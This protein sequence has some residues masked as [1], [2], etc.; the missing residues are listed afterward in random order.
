MDKRKLKRAVGIMLIL[1]MVIS[2]TASAFAASLNVTLTGSTYSYYSNGST[3]G[4]NKHGVFVASDPSYGAVFC[5]EHDRPEPM[6]IGTTKSMTIESFNNNN[7]IRKIL[8]YGYKGPAEW[9]GFSDSRYNNV[10]Q[11]FNGNVAKSKTQAC[12]VSVT[13]TALSIAYR[14]IGGNGSSWDV[15][16]LNA[17][18]NYINSKPAPPKGFEVYRMPGSGG[19]QDLF[20]WKYTPTG[21][22]TLTKGSNDPN[23]VVNKFPSHYSLAGAQYGVYTNSSLSNKVA[24]LTTNASGK[25]NKVTLDAG[26]YYIKEIKAPKGYVMDDKTYQVNIS[27]GNIVDLDV[28]D[29]AA[30]G[31]LA[32]KKVASNKDGVVDK[33]PGNYSLAG[34]EYTVYKDESLSASSKVGVLTTKSSGDTNM[35]VLPLG[36]YYVKETKASNGFKLDSKLH[37][38]KLQ[39]N[40][41]STITSTE[42][43][44]VGYAKLKKDISSDKHLTDLC[45]ENYSLAGAEYAVFDDSTGKKVGT[46]KTNAKGETAT[47]ALPTGSYYAK[48]IKAPKGFKLNSSETNTIT[49]KDGETKTFKATDAPS[50]DP[51][52]IK[53]KKTL[54]PGVDKNLSAAGAQYKVEYYKEFINEN[55]LEGKKPFRTWVIETK[56]INGQ[57]IAQLKDNYLVKDKSD[58]LFLNEKGRAV[59]LWG[60]YVITEELAPEGLARTEGIVSLQH[61]TFDEKLQTATV[62]KDVTAVEKAQTVSISISKVDKE[63]G[64]PVPQGYGSLEGAIFEISH[65]DPIKGENIV[66]GQVTT[67][68]KG[69]ASLGNL[70]PYTYK[71]KEIKAPDGYVKNTDI[72]E[73]KAGI[74]EPNTAN[75]DYEVEVPEQ[76]TITEIGKYEK[77]L[78]LNNRLEGA[79][80]QILDSNGKL[81]EEFTSTDKDFVIKGL[82]VGKYT[83]HEEKAPKGYV[84]AEDVP[85]EIKEDV[86]K[87]EVK[88][89]D[90]RVSAEKVDIETKEA[91][92]DAELAVKDSEGH[93]VD[94][95]TTDGEVHYISNLDYGK[96]YTLVETK[97]PAGYVIAEPVKF[98]VTGEDNIKIVMEDD[99]TKVQLNKVD[100]NNNLIKGAKLQLINDKKEVV[101][102]WTSTSKP[103]QFDRL[104]QGTYI[105]RETE[106]PEGYVKA[107]DVEVIVKDTADIQVGTMRDIR[108]YVE[109][110]DLGNDN[111][112][113]G[114][115]LEVRNSDGEVVDSWKSN[116]KPHYISNLAFGKSYTLVETKAPAGYVKI[117]PVDFTVEGLKDIEII[118]K[119][120]FIK[121][122][123]TK[124]MITGE[125]ELPGARLQVIDKDGN[126]IDEWVSSDK[127]HR[128]DRMPA[129]DYILKEI[130][131]A[132]GFVTAENIHF[133]VTE[134]GEV[135]VVTMRDEM[136]KT[137]ISKTDITTGENVV[138]AELSIYP[139]GEDGKAI[140][141][142]CFE[143]WITAETPH[144][145]EGLTIGKYVLREK[146]NS[147]AELGYVTA[148]EI[149]FEVK[150]TPEVQKV[151]MKDDYTK[152]E[153]TKNDVDGNPVVGATLSIVP[154]D[155]EGNPQYGE[156]FKTW[157]TE[158]DNPETKDIDESK[159]Y[160][161][162]L[163][164]GKYLLVENSAP[165]GYVKADPVE[166]EVKDTPEVQKYSMTDTR[167]SAVKV[168]TEGSSV[169]DVELTVFDKDG[170]EVD[171]WVTEGVKE[172]NHYISGLTENNEYVLKETKV[173]NGYV[174]AS[175]IT[176]TTSSTDNKK[177]I[178]VVMT[179]IR[180]SVNKT[181][182]DNKPLEGAELT[183]F[184]KDGNEIDKWI[185]DGKTHYITGLVE[186]SEYTLK[187]TKT[188]DGYATFEDIKFN[189]SEIK[190]IEINAIDEEIKVEITKIDEESK[191][192]LEGA[193][194]QVLNKEGKVVEEWT[195][196]T[197]AHKITKL[198]VGDY[199]LR[200]IEAPKG[201][202]KAQDQKFTVKD[203][204]EIQAFTLANEL[205]PIIPKTGDNSPILLYMLLLILSSGLIAAFKRKDVR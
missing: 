204:S 92:K 84:R 95:W 173:P 46:L 63:T 7:K 117:S 67:D 166:F 123:I 171:K 110:L 159:M 16:G 14:E 64:K 56:D 17:F 172:E 91:L 174:K 177:N 168:D 160:I 118:A 152:T 8:Y 154:I 90:I 193:K 34:A 181:S 143:T 120:D 5:G 96:T 39:H 105:M 137:L 24:T 186:N 146:L 79:V 60:T 13:S 140:E 121:V 136:T 26:K 103:V 203:T 86:V 66:D 114:A 82:P 83:L 125:D 57:Y 141:G 21:D 196:T 124:K 50:F 162:Y 132:D 10:Y 201:Y 106:A 3:A 179:D 138:G 43:P 37:T 98:T 29:T 78:L 99:F 185:T 1:V 2:N 93:I 182:E 71:V 75:F 191:K 27:S 19:S 73:V 158:S 127:P 12:G 165:E 89:V 62:L 70:K 59:G 109:K 170:N 164:I 87:T 113:E 200:E 195:S 47:L 88:M 183:V 20:T 190:D 40:K 33:Y 126:I 155:E 167:V 116:G 157:L 151:E 119:D 187:E 107:S 129:G 94:S 175:D 156:T 189:T 153:F 178:E 58:E 144:S 49:L 23:G 112:L 28:M 53:I 142:E 61:S 51:L 77:G 4:N 48:E 15:S 6:A 176:F 184:D 42:V 74:K 135:Q 97:A 100:A 36:T 38:V 202:E 122:D 192:P 22:L 139:L 18:T 150:D 11:L 41:I 81:I 68:S 194:L 101:E 52:S 65:F 197:S 198:P 128:I 188:P 133:T 35:L 108:V 44:K 9:S 102:E 134:T 131:P 104:P 205:T 148:N 85:F 45:P 130:K 111:P 55:Q 169:K 25:T 32:L 80:L 31:K 115:E 30:A 199:T 54:A 69:K 76:V 72:I 163:A 161:E 180:V 145:I 149:M 147:A